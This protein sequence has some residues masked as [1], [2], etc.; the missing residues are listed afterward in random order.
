MTETLIS[1][2]CSNDMRYEIVHNTSE[3]NAK[4][5]VNNRSKCTC[6]Q[7]IKMYVCTIDQNY[8]SSDRIELKN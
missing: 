2:A 1:T 4:V 8:G 3:A 7:Q 5:R 6:E